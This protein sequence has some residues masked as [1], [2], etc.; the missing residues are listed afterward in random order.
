MLG[1]PSQGPLGNPRSSEPQNKLEEDHKPLESRR[2]HQQDLRT[3]VPHGS[4][5]DQHDEKRPKQNNCVKDL[6]TKTPT[7]KKIGGSLSL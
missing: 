3:S 1:H 6:E 7:L 4:H 2:R 5:L